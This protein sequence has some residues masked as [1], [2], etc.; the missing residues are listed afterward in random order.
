[1]ADPELKVHFDYLEGKQL[2]TEE[3][4]A[5]RIVAE[6]TLMEVKDGVLYHVEKNGQLKL[7]PPK[8]MQ[9]QLMEDLHGGTCGAHLGFFKTVGRVT[10][11]YWWPEWRKD[12][13]LWCDR[14]RVC[15]SRRGGPIPRAPLTPIPVNQ[16]WELVGVDVLQMPKSRS[17]K[18]YIVVFVDHFT[19][20]PE[21]FATTNQEA[22]TIAKLLVERIVPVH[23]I[24]RKLLS[25]RGANF[26]QNS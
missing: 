23:G 22:I 16:P 1:M 9:T 14:C 21:A 12:L 6:S 25:D 4:R 10:A 3:A 7:I 13:K 24:P 26:N 20:W 8:E 15:Q 17:G 11:H 18:N 2:P 5:R 19:K